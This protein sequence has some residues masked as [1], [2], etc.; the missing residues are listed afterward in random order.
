MI[1]LD[2]EKALVRVPLLLVSIFNQRLNSN[3]TVDYRVQ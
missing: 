2:M 3:T 1:E